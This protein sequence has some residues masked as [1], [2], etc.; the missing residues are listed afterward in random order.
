MSNP[1]W[2]Y[3]NNYDTHEAYAIATAQVAITDPDQ[4]YICGE[5]GSVEIE[6]AIEP[7]RGSSARA[8]DSELAGPIDELVCYRDGA[9][10]VVREITYGPWRYVKPEEIENA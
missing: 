1:Q 9:R 7:D 6:Y 5:N 10:L 4:E 8:H 3:P 2:L